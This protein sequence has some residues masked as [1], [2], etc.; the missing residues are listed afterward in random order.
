LNATNLSTACINKLWRDA[1]CTTSKSIHINDA[2]EVDNWAKNQTK[3]GLIDDYRAW[4]TKGVSRER[5]M[6]CYNQNFP[7]S[8]FHLT[9]YNWSKAE[10]QD[11]CKV[12][13]PNARL[14]T[15]NELVRAQRAGAD[16]CSTGWVSDR[17]SAHYP[18]TRSRAGCGNNPGIQTYLPPSGKAGVNCYGIK[19][20]KTTENSSKIAPFNE[21]VWDAASRPEVF[22]IQG[23]NWTKDEALD[24][25]KVYDSNARLATYSEL[26][27]ANRAGADWCSTGW[28]SDKDTAHYPIIV[29]RSGCSN[30]PGIQTYLPPSGKAGVNCYGIKPA[31][32]RDLAPFNSFY[33]S[34]NSALPVAEFFENGDY[35]GEV[36]R[37]GPGRHN[38]GQ[39]GIGNDTISSIRVPRGLVVTLYQYGDFNGK[40]KIIDA[41]ENDVYLSSLGTEDEFNWNDQTSSIE[42][43]M[44]IPDRIAIK[45]GRL[46]NYCAENPRQVEFYSDANYGGNVTRLGPGRH[47]L[48]SNSINIGDTISSM[49]IPRG[50]IVYAY[51]NNDFTGNAKIFDGLENGL[52]VPTM[53][54]DQLQTGNFSWNDQISSVEIKSR[55]QC[56]APWKLGWE[57][58]K[59]NNLGNNQ[60]SLTGG[61]SNKIC[62]DD[63]VDIG[64]TCNRD[65]VGAW[66]KFTFE[67]LGDNYYAL[68]GGY[69]NKYCAVKGNLKKDNYLVCN[70]D[71]VGD[72]ERF[73]WETVDS[74]ATDSRPFVINAKNG[75]HCVHPAGGSAANGTNAVFHDGCDLNQE[76]LHFVMTPTGAIKHKT[77]GLCLRV[78]SNDANTP[79]KFDSR[80]E[81]QFDWDDNNSLRHR[82]SGNC[83]HPSGGSVSNNVNLVIHPGCGEDK[84]HLVQK[85][86]DY[87]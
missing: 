59:V 18:I 34:E 27:Q 2:G 45:E 37:L 48:H 86:W 13:D 53:P 44:A 20:T 55:A 51:Q 65:A 46:G 32:T 1:G 30:S 7:R 6:A 78:D 15:Y 50:F 41:T 77:S 35:T 60:I 68:K 38:I 85:A 40:K 39:M 54:I 33:W 47:D 63:G 83:I 14:A 80:C 16:W 5:D 24:K 21:S 43:R 81:N 57:Q 49:K 70:R 56:G 17:S 29:P 11:Q 8:V 10:A 62:A 19:P 87:E 61:S 75:T 3:Q 82:D 71:F 31:Q 64:V 66:E 74:P 25:C 26:E 58:F 67:P 4:S 9:G 79:V 28:V 36:T 73:T 42:V 76:R 84:N 52:N 22:H 23:Y 69:N 12:Y 72:W